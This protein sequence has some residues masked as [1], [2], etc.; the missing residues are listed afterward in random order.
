[1]HVKEGYCF[2]PPK[3]VTSPSWGPPPPCKQALSANLCTS[4][5]A[6]NV[7]FFRFHLRLGMFNRCVASA[8][9]VF[10]FIIL[11]FFHFNTTF[12]PLLSQKKRML[13]AELHSRGSVAPQLRKSIYRRNLGKHVTVHRPPVRP[14]HRH[15]NVIYLN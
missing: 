9:N 13:V 3:Q 12:C 10:H 6:K 15:T 14:H 1:M 5:K 2:P 11:F 4:G 8:L 7:I